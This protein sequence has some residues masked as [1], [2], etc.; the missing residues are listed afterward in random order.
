MI[1][2]YKS[3]CDICF[4]VLARPADTL[5]AL[6]RQVLPPGSN[7]SFF[8]SIFD[9]IEALLSLGTHAPV[10]LITRPATLA[11]PHLPTILQQFPNLRILGWLCS[12]ET[13]DPFMTARTAQPMITVSG[14]EQLRSVIAA[15]VDSLSAS[16]LTHNAP[17]DAHTHASALDPA[18]FRL[19]DE[20]LDA[21][22]GADL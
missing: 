7:I 8:N 13:A 6:A 9:V 14:H 21:L 19:S 20:E 1:P 18:H 17:A 11:R 3:N 4:W 22:L 12:G 2:N 15:L 5:S 16:L 10:V